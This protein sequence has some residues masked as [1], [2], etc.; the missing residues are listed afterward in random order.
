MSVARSMAEYLDQQFA[1]ACTQVSPLPLPFAVKYNYQPMIG[2]A[3]I[4]KN[5]WKKGFI[6]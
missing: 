2:V 5:R 6:C 3:L 4:D 1:V